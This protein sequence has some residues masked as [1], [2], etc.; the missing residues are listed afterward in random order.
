VWSEIP[1]KEKNKD[2]NW[3]CQRLDTIWDAVYP[4]T[5]DRSKDILQIKGLY[6]R[7]NW[8]LFKDELHANITHS[9]YFKEG[10]LIYFDGTLSCNGTNMIV[11]LDKHLLI[12]D[13]D[14]G[15]N[16]IDELHIKFK[17][18]FKQ[19]SKEDTLFYSPV[20]FVEL[21]SIEEI[22]DT[23]KLSITYKTKIINKSGVEYLCDNFG[24]FI[25]PKAGEVVKT[26]N[27]D[28]ELKKHEITEREKTRLSMFNR[29]MDDLKE[30]LKD[31][32]ITFKEFSDE[33]K[34][35]YSRYK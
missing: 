9:P 29:E 13:S 6:P 20:P 1:T 12:D 4:I 17:E 27:K 21:V 5:K 19:R 15:L 22:D 14:E 32:T 34:E 18:L 7:E 33:K 16:N 3:I 26:E 28:F 23:G 25:E 31:K 11:F 24:E 10:D 35:I 2:V 30:L 8:Y